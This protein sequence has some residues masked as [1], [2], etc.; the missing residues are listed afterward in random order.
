M[1]TQISAAHVASTSLD[2]P[3]LL[4]AGRRLVTVTLYMGLA[5]LYV[6]GLP[7]WLSLVVLVD[8]VRGP[9]RARPRTRAQAGAPAPWSP[10]NTT[11]SAA[12]LATVSGFRGMAGLVVGGSLSLRS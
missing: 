12:A 3:R 8:L 9:I 5:S 4:V 7:L 11:R 1:T 6:G 2:E 10:G